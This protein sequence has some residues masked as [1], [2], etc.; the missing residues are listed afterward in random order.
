MVLGKLAHI[1]VLIHILC[2]CSLPCHPCL[3][4]WFSW[5]CSRAAAALRDP[6]HSGLEFLL[7]ISASFSACATLADNWEGNQKIPPVLWSPVL[8]F[9]VQLLWAPLLRQHSTPLPTSQLF[10]IPFLLPKEPVSNLV[11]VSLSFT[12]GSLPD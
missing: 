11:I 8:V 7:I 10:I 1:P 4:T 3:H 2:V 9:T 5:G 6:C 12:S